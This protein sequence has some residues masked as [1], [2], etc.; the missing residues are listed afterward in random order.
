MGHVMW[1]HEATSILNAVPGITLQLAR[2]TVKPSPQVVPEI[3][4]AY[5]GRHVG[6]IEKQVMDDR[7]HRED[8]YTGEE[9]PRDQADLPS[10]S[11]HY[12][13][14]WPHLFATIYARIDGDGKRRLARE[15]ARR[16]FKW[17][18]YSGRSRP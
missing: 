15:C 13:S 11:M 17:W 7:P 18:L 6:Y 8:P 16:G 12:R 10:A 5:R 14:A 4:V 2:N 9:F 3:G 1:I